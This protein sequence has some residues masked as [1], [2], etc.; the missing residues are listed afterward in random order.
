[1]KCPK[2]GFIS[3]KD[4]FRCPYCGTVSEE[5][6]DGIR[7]RINI[8][9]DFSIQIRTILILLAFNLFF[10]SILL[11]W[12]FDFA[13]SITLWSFFVLFGSLL[14]VDISTSKKKNIIISMQKF[15]AFVLVFLMLGCGLF[16]I[17]GVFD[18]RMYFPSLIL[19]AFLIISMT[20]STVMFFVRKKA[21]VRPI[22]TETFFAL[23]LTIAIILFVFFLVNKYC[24]ANGVTNPPFRYM[25]LDMVD[26]NR[27][28][29]YTISE[30][31]IFASFGL[32]LITLTNFNI[33]LIGFIYRK[34]KKIYGGERD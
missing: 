32:S 31:L 19:P 9:N 21:R 1:M 4:F 8:G 29:L 23:Y 30:I 16:Q 18:F 27:T 20:L 17:R 6:S 5:S 13:Y 22:W 7:T 2:C 14:I 34:V 10:L 33:I 24:V 3:N 12:Y 15:F 11:D 26:G 25:Q 28:T